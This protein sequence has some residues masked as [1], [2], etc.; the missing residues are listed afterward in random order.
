MSTA[1]SSAGLEGIDFTGL[2]YLAALALVGLFGWR[3]YQTAKGAATALPD[4]IQGAAQAVNPANPDNVVNRAANAA[5][6]AATGTPDT[7]GTWIYN[8][9]HT[10]EWARVNAEAPAAS[11]PVWTSGFDLQD[12]F[13]PPS[14]VGTLPRDQERPAIIFRAPRR[15]Q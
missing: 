5:L 12:N 3:V 6:Q 15:T 10:D 9:T 13:P 1:R 11:A 8:A 2:A 4:A 14:F 7:V